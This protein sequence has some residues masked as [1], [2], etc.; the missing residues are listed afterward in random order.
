MPLEPLPHADLLI[1]AKTDDVGRRVREGEDGPVVAQDAVK[2]CTC[3][4]VP[5]AYHT[6]LSYRKDVQ[7]MPDATDTSL[8]HLRT[9]T[10][11]A[12]N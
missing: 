1:R 3:Q 4:Q 11:T 12:G 8:G 5:H 6:I 7:E 10:S 9:R 2:A